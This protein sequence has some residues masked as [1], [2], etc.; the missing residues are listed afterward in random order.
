M[1]RVRLGIVCTEFNE[2]VM[3]K[4]LDAATAHAEFLNAEI[5]A[6]LRVPGS[7][8][9]CLAAKTLLENSSI[10]AVVCLG[11]IIQ[12]ET[13]HDE[14]IGYSTSKTLQELSIKYGKPIG[15]GIC[16]PRMTY[17]QA[18][19][20]AV[21]FAQ[22]AVKTAIEMHQMLKTLKVKEAKEKKD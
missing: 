8:D 6:T 1:K 11:A 18:E 12:G 19:N 3:E 5:A 4:M 2:G 9:V 13:G 22:H 17:K 21:P 10:D 16:G 15:F 14:V 20:R 7:W